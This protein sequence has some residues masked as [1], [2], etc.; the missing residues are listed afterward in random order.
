M[1]NKQTTNTLLKGATA[2]SLFLFI[3]LGMASCSQDP[4]ADEMKASEVDEVKA[5][6]IPEVLQFTEPALYPE[7]IAHDRFNQQF[8]VSSITTGDIGA[9]SYAG[10]YTPY[11]QD[12]RFISTLGLQ[13]DEARKRLLVAGADAGASPQSSP[14]TA[15]QQAL[16]GIYDLRSGANLHFVDLGA[17]RPGMPHFANDIALDNQGNA[18]VTDSFSPII[19]KVDVNGNASVFFENQAFAT[20]T[21]EFGF[22]GIV[23][24]A[25]GYLLVAHS[26]DNA[27][28]K[29]PVRD[30]EAYEKVT[31]NALLMGPDGLLLSRN[32]KQLIVVNN[33]GGETSG[34]VLSFTSNDKW[35]TGMLE[36]SFNTGVTFPT[37]ATTYGKDVYVLYAHLHILLGGIEPPQS[38]YAIRKVPFS[39]N[40][41]F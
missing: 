11:I 19:Y 31:L 9:V 32:G 15:G 36:E 30:P 28:Y 2:Y 5:K 25:H 33:A 16:L 26:A 21:G 13:V 1:K 17:L 8:L 23:Y 10:E 12:N 20:E 29:I 27:V 39:G 24:H 7:G 41:Q 14:A 6:N 34:Q 38:D 3:L 18:Y 22:N 40:W 4:A 37:T 35:G